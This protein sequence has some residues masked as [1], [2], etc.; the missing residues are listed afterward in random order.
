MSFSFTTFAFFD[1][2][3]A[4]GRVRSEVQGDPETSLGVFLSLH[5]DGSIP[6]DSS[7]PMYTSHGHYL[8][9]A[10]L[11]SL[12]PVLQVL[13]ILQWVAY[14]SFVAP[15]MHL[16]DLL[17]VPSNQKPLEDA[18]SVKDSSFDMSGLSAANQ[19]NAEQNA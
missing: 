7:T 4:L 19:T 15:E 3:N 12:Q 8:L 17:E 5:N 6:V 1:N 18:L 16:L 10:T 14:S 9:D 2:P 13:V 11:Q